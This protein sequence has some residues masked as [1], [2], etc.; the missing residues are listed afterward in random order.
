MALITAEQSREQGHIGPENKKFDKSAENQY[1][2]IQFAVA[3]DYVFTFMKLE[4]I[5]DRK[6]PQGIGT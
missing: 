2:L 5:E 1:F 6:H 3:A 4:E